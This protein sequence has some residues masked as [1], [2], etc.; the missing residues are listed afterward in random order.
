MASRE[1]IRP[2][3][4]RMTPYELVTGG[5]ARSRKFALYRETLRT[6]FLPAWERLRRSLPRH[7]IPAATNCRG[8]RQAFS[9]HGGIY[10]PDVAGDQP[11]SGPIASR[12]PAPSPGR[13]TLR[14]DH[15]LLIVRDEFRPAIPRRVAR[16]HCPPPLHRHEQINMS[17]S[18]ETAKGDVS[19]LPARG[20]F[21]FA[22][23]AFLFKL[24]GAAP[25]DVIGSQTGHTCRWAPDA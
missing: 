15:A 13:R 19:T 2:S 18:S 12:R 25:H 7:S 23:T 11:G 21:Y 17:S 14:E 1:G 3:A 8:P 16:Q 22:L 4:R 20:H 24:T 6:G 5:V 10:R 9:R